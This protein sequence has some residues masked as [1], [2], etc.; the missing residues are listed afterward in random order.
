MSKICKICGIE[1]NARGFS[2]HVVKKHKISMEEYEKMEEENNKELGTNIEIEQDNNEEDD[3]EVEIHDEKKEESNTGTNIIE[4]YT[5]T[6]KEEVDEEV[7]GNEDVITDEEDITENETTND[8]EEIDQPA[9]YTGIIIQGFTLTNPHDFQAYALFDINGVEVKK[10]IIAAGLAII[11]D[12]S[13]PCGLVLTEMGTIIPPFMIPGFTH[14]QTEEGSIKTNE[15]EKNERESNEITKIEEIEDNI[16]SVEAH[17]TEKDEIP[18]I[19][20][21]PD[22]LSSL[23][24]ELLES[25]NNPVEEHVDIK[26]ERKKSRW[27]GNKKGKKNAMESE[28]HRLTIE[29]NGNKLEERKLNNR[30]LD[31]KL[32]L[33]LLEY[34]TLIREDEL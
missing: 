16:D 10:P 23:R 6:E 8:E 34:K 17:I 33:A 22:L 21:N 24:N 20:E 9:E 1:Y 12:E 5:E 7:A 27:W 11:G 13:I 3:Q 14:V 28:L 15:T 4:D 19:P 2:R 26:K 25:N 31:T 30:E 32:G 29:N 18:I